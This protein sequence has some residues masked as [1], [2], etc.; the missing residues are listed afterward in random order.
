MRTRFLGDAIPPSFGPAGAGGGP[1]GPGASLRDG[2]EAAGKNTPG[3]GVRTETGSLRD[4]AWHPFPTL[5]SRREIPHEVQRLHAFWFSPG[6]QPGKQPISGAFFGE[7]YIT[8]TAV[9]ES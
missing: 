1:L 7:G 9:I 6:K 4:N 2:G 8:T 3:S 5:S